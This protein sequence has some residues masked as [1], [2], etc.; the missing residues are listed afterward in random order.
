MHEEEK[1]PFRGFESRVVTGFSVRAGIH[2]GLAAS[3][4]CRI[5][6]SKELLEAR[7]FFRHASPSKFVSYV[8]AFS[9]LF[10]IQVK[11]IEVGW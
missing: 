11:K 1:V 8:L 10:N 6:N 9:K 7:Y 5:P 2:S 4:L 3:D